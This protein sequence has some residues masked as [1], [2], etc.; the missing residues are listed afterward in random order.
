MLYVA[1]NDRTCTGWEFCSRTEMPIFYAYTT[2][3]IWKTIKFRIF[4]PATANSNNNKITDHSRRL[5]MRGRKRRLPAP[6][7]NS[8]DCVNGSTH[9]IWYVWR[10]TENRLNSRYKTTN[11]KRAHTIILEL[12]KIIRTNEFLVCFYGIDGKSVDRSARICGVRA[13]GGGL[14]LGGRKV[15][16]NR[17]PLTQLQTTNTKLCGSLFCMAAWSSNA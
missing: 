15:H 14:R 3:I 17:S 11:N 4:I 8:D 16:T 12:V 9:C 5:M 1:W 7:E 13:R 6:F 10:S 2:F